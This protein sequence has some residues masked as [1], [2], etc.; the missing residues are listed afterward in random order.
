MTA[1]LDHLGVVP[2][3]IV[4]LGLCLKVAL[5]LACARLTARAVR[6]AGAAA[7]HRA[8]AVAFGSVAALVVAQP[9]APRIP[10]A[11]PVTIVPGTAGAAAHP[12]WPVIP[13]RAL[14]LAVRL[15]SSVWLA[16]AVAMAARLALGWIAA[17]RLVRGARP[18]PRAWAGGRVRVLMSD[19]LAVPVVCGVLRPAVVLPADAARWTCARRDAVLRHE[20]AHIER[21]DTLLFALAELAQVLFWFD[22]QVR[23]GLR[24]LR[25]AA[26]RACDDRVLE[27]GW[28]PF[29]Y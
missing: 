18:A 14:V 12:W 26:E 4:A 19:R 3:P 6:P 7:E 5:A 25:R 23:H 2:E 8:W 22:P 17:G 20:R 28:P 16:G 29:E 9:F 21:H 10:V 27:S 1:W 11:L 13:A 15:A 24:A